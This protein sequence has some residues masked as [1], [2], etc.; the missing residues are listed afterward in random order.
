MLD[1]L[2]FSRMDAAK[3]LI[4]VI[5]SVRNGEQWLQQ[6]IDSILH[7]TWTNWEFII[8]DDASDQPAKNIL[9]QYWHDRRF[10]I[11]FQEN[12]QGLTKNLN[13]AI[14]LCNGEYIARM[15]GDDFSLPTRFEKQVSYLQLHADTIMVASTVEMINEKGES[16]GEWKDD[17]QTISTEAITHKL[18]FTNCIAHPSVLFVASGL[19]KYRYNERQTHSQ[20]W[21]LWLRIVAD[22]NVIAKLDEP[23]LR[24]RVHS[25]SITGKRKI[26][27]F[28]K[29][30]EMYERYFAVAS[31]NAFNNKVK[32]AAK[33]NSV[34][35]FLSNIKR[36]LSS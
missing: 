6:A 7:Q 31:A 23:L 10:R 3:P 19:R 20:D 15:D 36:S 5:M 22:D 35:L 9:G 14:A 26:S 25:N 27:V 29:K 4:S 32:R 11:V 16:I 13:M 2:N 8:I 33:M 18:P 17:R 24:Y 21:D 28:A 12:A 1:P 34:K 30:A